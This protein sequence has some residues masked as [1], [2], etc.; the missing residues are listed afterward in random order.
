M[1]QILEFKLLLIALLVLAPATGNTSVE[2]NGMIRKP[3]A[4][5]MDDKLKIDLS[6]LSRLAPLNTRGA[7]TASQSLLLDCEKIRQGQRGLA[8]AERNGAHFTPLT[9]DPGSLLIR[10]RVL[11]S[12]DARYHINR[13]QDRFSALAQRFQCKS[14]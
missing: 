13:N 4:V 12:V 10:P 5:R 2:A 1:R 11:P 3:L 9:P 7:S 6:D 8:E 14:R